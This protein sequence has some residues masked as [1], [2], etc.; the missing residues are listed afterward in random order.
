MSGLSIRA[1]DDLDG[2]AALESAWWDLWRRTPTATPFQSPAWLIAWRRI[3]AP[4]PLRVGAVFDGGQLV[5]LFP[6]YEEKNAAGSRLLPLGISVS[7]YLD[8]L[9]DPARPEELQSLAAFIAETPW[10][11]CS[12]EELPPSAIARSLPPPSECSD[13][14]DRH[15]ACPVL[16]LRGGRDLV[17]CVPARRRRQLRRARAAAARLGEVQIE[18]ADH[19]SD[20]FLAFAFSLHAARWRERG[21]SGVLSDEQ[22]RRFHR[23]ALPQLAAA[24][25]AR[26]Y[27]LAIGGRNVAAY[28]GFLDRGRAFAYLGGFDPA[29]EDASPG[30]I[31]IGHAIEKAIDEDAREF[32]FLR[33]REAYKYSW[34]ATDRWNQR[35]LWTRRDDA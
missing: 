14:I 4:G 19:D 18:R 1:I 25:L 33:G 5:A 13:D 23:T 30:A 16:V 22:V 6:F 35:R 34:G 27:L 7:D 17:G 15:S 29:F 31:L 11:C 32:H 9:A 8:I 26:C 24:G 10:R 20:R 3:F 21:E 2:L 12:F 28:Y